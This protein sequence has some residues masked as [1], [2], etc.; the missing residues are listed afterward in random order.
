MKA[1][2]YIGY[3]DP[4]KLRMAEVPRPKPS[5]DQLLVKVAAG[6]VNPVDWKLHDGSLRFLVPVRFPSIPGFDLAGDV[7]EAGANVRRFRPGDRV[8]ACLSFRNFGSAAEFALVEEGLAAL[9]PKGM[10]DHEAAA[11]PLAGL[12]ALQALRDLGRLQKGHRVLIVGAS[13]GVGHYAVQIAKALGANVFAVCSTANVSW[14]Q[15]LGA[16]EVIDYTQTA[17][18]GP[19]ASFDLIL[20]TVVSGPFGRYQGLLKADGIY[21]STLPKI[22]LMARSWALKLFSKKR[23]KTVML[24]SNGDDLTFLSTLSEQGRLRSVIDSV[25]PLSQLDLAHR[26]SQSGHARGKIV[27]EVPNASAESA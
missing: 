12:T 11:L 25:F 1:M 8:M 3:G 23:I 6:S 2:Q 24:K 10:N 9:I 13:G 18:F 21:V 26:R 16:D 7:V 14:V 4:S 5:P 15:E 22:G 20:D 27:I 19:A 17:E